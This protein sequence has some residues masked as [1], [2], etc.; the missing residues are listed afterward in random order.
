MLGQMEFVCLHDSH[1]K[2]HRLL[3]TRS[4][5]MLACGQSKLDC[6]KV[7]HANMHPWL[8]TTLED[9]SALQALMN[10]AY[11]SNVYRRYQHLSLFYT[12]ASC[13]YLT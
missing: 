7:E 4:V 11:S 13:L 2:L 5:Y 3:R 8:V 12:S 1:E 9:F 10:N 6:G